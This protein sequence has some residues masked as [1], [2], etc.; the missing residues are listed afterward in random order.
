MVQ[1]VVSAANPTLKLLRSLH[2]KKHRQ[3]SGLFL[4]EGAR[5][6]IEAAAHGF[7]P[8]ILACTQAALE[9][10]AVRELLDGAGARGAKIVR[11]SEALLAQV[12]RRD[13]TQTLIGAYRQR[14]CDLEAL[15]PARRFV[16]L[17]SIRD[18]GNL[19]TIL[20]TADA[21][22]A[23][24]VVLLDGGCD[25]FSIEAVRASMG[26]IFAMPVVRAQSAAFLA[27]R[28]ARGLRL[29]G[30][31]LLG[32]KP[33]EA[34]GAVE[35]A[36]LLMGNEQSGLPPAL[37]AACDDRVRLPMAGS[38]DSLNLAIATGVALYGIWRAQGYDG[39]AR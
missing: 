27:W 19:G 24:G 36:C 26:S 1:D 30:L 2:A 17:E 23:G 5:S 9:R 10:P 34:L 7:W 8:E 12:T 6:A 37:E 29:I 31:T 33:L 21:A 3:D 28:A 18:P 35:A 15:A 4:A 38:A 16:A 25:P 22:G 32:S 39:A 11:T 14:W 13:N 20:R